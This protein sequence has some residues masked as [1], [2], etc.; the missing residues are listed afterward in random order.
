MEEKL[1]VLTELIKMARADEDVR[2][3][4]YSLMLAMANVLGVSKN[5]FDR[6]FEE[7]IQIHTPAS[8]F[9]RILQFHRLILVAKIDKNLHPRELAHLRHCGHR[10]HF[11]P[12]A[13]D[14]VMDL[15]KKSGAAAPSVEAMLAI[16]KIYH[17]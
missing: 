16:F 11:R 2:Q 13:I 3:E 15:I 1:S 4:E 8:E 12:E 5:E 6:L 7:N 14:Q 10:L 17:N 9:E